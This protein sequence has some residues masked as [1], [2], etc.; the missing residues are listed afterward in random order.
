[1]LP[2]TLP[3]AGITIL[4]VLLVSLYR[5]MLRR[6][7][8]MRI[9]HLEWHPGESR[10]AALIL[11]S[12]EAASSKDFIKYTRRL[13]AEQKLNRIVIDECHLTVI[14]AEYRPSIVQLITIRSLRTQFVYLTATL[15][16]SMRAEFDKR[17]YLHHPKIIRA[18]SNRLNIFY[19]VRKVDAH[20]GSLLKQ[21]ASEAEQAWKES[22]FFDRAR[23]KIILSVS[24]NQ[25][26]QLGGLELSCL[27]VD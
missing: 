10:E 26:T 12:A 5:D 8:E 1:M 7:R 14:A 23:D 21:A 19:M 24:N 15:P 18:S 9:D 13:I 4:I 25:S 2:Y 11:V 3:D 27:P 16:L 17:N 20:N 6:V 22:G